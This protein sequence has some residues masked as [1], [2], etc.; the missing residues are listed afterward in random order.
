MKKFRVYYSVNA[1]LLSDIFDAV[2]LQHALEQVDLIY[3][4]Y[5]S[6]DVFILSVCQCPSPKFIPSPVP[7]DIF[8][9]DFV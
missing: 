4:C 8:S 9:G 3:D 7:I 1:H 2:D 6:V 5:D